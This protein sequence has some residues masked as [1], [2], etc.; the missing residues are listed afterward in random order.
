MGL[1]KGM[2]NNLGGRK[3]GSKNKVSADMKSWVKMLIES[4]TEQLEADLKQL[5][6][7]DKWLIVEKLLAYIVPKATISIDTTISPPARVL[8]KAEIK[9]LIHKLEDNY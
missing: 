5:E 6:P 4:N 2:C 3:R 8:S 7:K 1:K 9:E